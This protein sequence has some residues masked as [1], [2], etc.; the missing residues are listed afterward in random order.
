MLNIITDIKNAKNVENDSER[1][2]S[3]FR[4]KGTDTDKALLKE[5]DQ[6]EYLDS[7]H[8]LDRFGCKIHINDISTG[9]KCA[10]NVA[11]NSNIWINT[12]ECGCNARDAII[13]HCNDG[14][15]VLNN[16]GVPIDE[17]GFGSINVNIDGKHMTN[18][19]DLNDYLYR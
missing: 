1:L 16:L 4:I 7:E 12:L 15:I 13:R 14:N 2:F 10:L 8:V 5:I 3:T 11:N 17:S 18:I 19:S 6:A 9:C